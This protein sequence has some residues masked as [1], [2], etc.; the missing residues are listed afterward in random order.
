MVR[1]TTREGG[2]RTQGAGSAPA[3]P[4]ARGPGERG[5]EVH[6]LQAAHPQCPSVEGCDIPRRQKCDTDP[7]GQEAAAAVRARDPGLRQ[8]HQGGASSFADGCLAGPWRL[9]TEAPAGSACPELELRQKPNFSPG[10]EHSPWKE[11]LCPET[12]PRLAC[13]SCF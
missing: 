5:A 3:S 12:S 6:R 10:R 8:E 1:T 11:G 2:R 9:R 4:R 7:Q 13:G